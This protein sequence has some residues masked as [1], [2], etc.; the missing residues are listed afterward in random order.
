MADDQV[1]FFFDSDNSLPAS[2][3]AIIISKRDDQYVDM[4]VGWD[5]TDYLL[6]PACDW[7]DIENI[8]ANIFSPVTYQNNGLMTSSDKRKIDYLNIVQSN[9]SIT[10]EVI[11]TITPNTNQQTS[12]EDEGG[13]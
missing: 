2:D 10:G 11:F 12:E 1:R 9:D 7:E 6:K 5:S 4:H 13:F 3:G 8:P